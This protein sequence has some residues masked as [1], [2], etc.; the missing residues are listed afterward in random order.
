VC[1]PAEK[2]LGRKWEEVTAVTLTDSTQFC[3]D[4][5][6]VLGWLLNDAASEA[7]IEATWHRLLT[8]KK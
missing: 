3:Y 6:S 2:E 4:C 1:A 8:H 5:G 7:E